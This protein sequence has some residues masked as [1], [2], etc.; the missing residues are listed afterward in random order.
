MAV[1]LIDEEKLMIEVVRE[2]AREK[3]APA[4]R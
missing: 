1:Q 4:R 3:V 2:L